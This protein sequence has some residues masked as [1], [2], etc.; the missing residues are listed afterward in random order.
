MSRLKGALTD[1]LLSVVMPVYNEKDTIAEIIP[2]VLAVPVRKELIVVDD[3]SKDGTRDMLPELQ[4]QYGDRGVQVVAV[5]VNNNEADGMPKMKERAEEKGF[6]FPYLYDP[7]QKIARDYG[8]RV[9]PD[10]VLLDSNGKVAY[11]GLID[12]NIYDPSGVKEPHLVAAIDAVLAGNTPPQI[13]TKAAG[14]GIQF[15]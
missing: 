2:R 8:A 7:T 13:E 14:C 11:M 3:G 4:K 1:P 15:E 12:D 9:T 6:N 10:V 5:N